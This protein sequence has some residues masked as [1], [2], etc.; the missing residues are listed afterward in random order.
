[1]NDVIDSL[2]GLDQQLFLLFNRDLAFSFGDQFFPAITDL[3]KTWPFK[4][5]FVPFLLFLFVRSRKWDGVVIFFGFALTLGLA[6]HIGS[7]LKHLFGRP[8]PFEVIDAIQRSPAG[9][10]S[11]PSNH[12]VSMFAMAFFMSYFFPKLRWLFFTIAILV[13]YSRIYNGVHY[14]SDIIFG[15]VIGT[16]FGIAGSNLIQRLIQRIHVWRGARG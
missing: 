9:G 5:V 13:S 15:F 1:M 2:I 14:P 11:F 12:A 10:F 7:R 6:D 3:H 8:R 16:L 4:F